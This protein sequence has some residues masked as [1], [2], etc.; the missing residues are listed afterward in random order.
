MNPVVAEPRHC[1]CSCTQDEEQ[2]QDALPG[3]PGAPESDPL[4]VSAPS[5]VEELFVFLVQL[6]VQIRAPERV[7][8]RAPRRRGRRRPR[9]RRVSGLHSTRQGGTSGC[10]GVK[11]S[12]R[13]A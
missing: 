12:S 1:A 9:R 5:A 6:R 8:F 11:P 4:L 2:H 7:G 3:I 13:Q 10:Q